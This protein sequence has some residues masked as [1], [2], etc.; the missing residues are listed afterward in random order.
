MNGNT[1]YEKHMMEVIKN[2]GDKLRKTNV[3]TE[4]MWD[5]FLL[6]RM[7]VKERLEFMTAT[8][9]YSCCGEHYEGKSKKVK[10]LMEFYY[11]LSDLYFSILEGKTTEEI[12]KAIEE[13]VV[14]GEEDETKGI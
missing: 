4:G 9:F 12:K 3:V 6:L 2:K 1:D 10:A 13:R 5:A 7:T 14:I 8:H 11:P